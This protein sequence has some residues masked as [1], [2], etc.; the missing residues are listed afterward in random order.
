MIYKKQANFPYPVLSQLTSDYPD[1]SFQLSVS[2]SEVDNQY[3][4]TLDYEIKNHFINRLLKDKSAEIYAVIQSKDGKFFKLNEGNTI[5]IPKENISLSKRTEIQ[6]LI[7][8]KRRISFKNNDELDEFFIKHKDKIFVDP[9]SVLAISNVERFDGDIKKPFNLFEMAVDPSLTSEIKIELLQ[10]TIC[11]WYKHKKYQYYEFNYSKSLSNPHIYIGLERALLNFIR[12]NGESG[13]VDLK[14]LETPEN[15]LD[16]KLFDLMKK[17]EVWN[18]NE[19]RLDEI[20]YKITDQ[21]IEKHY[22]A[23]KRLNDYAT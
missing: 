5:K 2:V 13:E 9:Y 17:K 18:V 23:I 10:E 15:K 19:E 20:I 8:T 3:E 14:E 7:M 16:W 12:N 4:F 1:S 22:K 6:L 21:L 11:I